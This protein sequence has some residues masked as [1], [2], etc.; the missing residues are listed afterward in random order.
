MVKDSSHRGRSSVAKV[1]VSVEDQIWAQFHF[2]PRVLF[3]F[4]YVPPMDSQ[5]YSHNSFASIQEKLKTNTSCNEFCIIGDQNARFGKYARELLSIL[6]S[7]DL[8][9]PD[10]YS[11][12]ILANDI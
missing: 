4:C 2:A 3:G 10:M 12:P 9:H 7:V 6:K 1:D 5:Y 11:Y 8:A